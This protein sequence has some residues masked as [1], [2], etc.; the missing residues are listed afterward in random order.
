LNPDQITSLSW[1][2]HPDFDE[3]VK[4]KAAEIVAFEIQNPALRSRAGA[5]NAGLTMLA[6]KDFHGKMKMLFKGNPSGIVE[7]ASL[8]DALTAVRNL[9]IRIEKLEERIS[10]LK[11]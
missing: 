5:D 6:D 3:T 4:L 1:W 8:A 9:K 2:V 7:F 11:R 10:K